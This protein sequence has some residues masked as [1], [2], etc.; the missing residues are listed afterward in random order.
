[1][2]NNIYFT[3]DQAREELKR[4]WINIDLKNKIENEISNNFIM[5]FKSNPRGVT[6]R[7]VCSPDNGFDFFYQCSKYVNADPLIIEFHDDIFVSF[8]EEK[9]GLGRLRIVC[10]DDKKA[11]VDIM[12]FHENEKKKLSEC[13]LKNGESLLEFHRNLLQ[14]NY[15]NLSIIDISK[16][17]KNIGKAKDYYYYFLLHF[18]CHGAL[19]ECFS[20]EEECEAIFTRDIIIPAIN[21]IEKKIGLKPVIIKLYPDNQSKEEDFYWFRYPKS[22]ND[23][24][25]KYAKDRSYPIK[26]YK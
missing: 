3:L 6:F 14:K 20:L 12:N 5:N 8:N 15:T 13:I 19:F 18:V 26:E 7:Q 1:M 11:V 17:C 9:K 10:E 22:I 25:I 4:R 24:I 23:D 2:N 16:W 21:K